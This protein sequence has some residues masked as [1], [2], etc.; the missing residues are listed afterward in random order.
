MPADTE[1]A[2]DVF[3]QCLAD[4]IKVAGQL[5]AQIEFSI[6]AKTEEYSSEVKER[7]RKLAEDEVTLP[8]QNKEVFNKLYQRD[9]DFWRATRRAVVH[10]LD[11][12]EKHSRYA[13]KIVKNFRQGMYFPNVDFHHGTIEN[14]LESRLAG[15]HGN[16]F[17][18]HAI[19]DLPDTHKYL[20]LVGRALRPGG[21]LLTWNPNLTQVMAC[22]E[23]VREKKLPFL[24]EK[25]LEVGVGGGVGGREW[26]VRRA[27]LK[28]SSEPRQVPEEPKEFVDEV[29]ASDGDEVVE[30]LEDK[31][32]VLEDNARYE[33]I[34]RPKVGARVIGGGF[35]GLWRRME[36]F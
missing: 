4:Y 11:I 2:D 13:Q 27:K 18:G 35:I 8:E 19:L 5:G 34:C 31:S 28:N 23:I 16:V 25:V 22:V 24:L 29:A 3:D 21:S 26:D 7:F 20:E 17:L 36:Q 9:Y 32:P 1:Q 10:T 14:Y 33:M 12:N 30:N 15:T 6:L